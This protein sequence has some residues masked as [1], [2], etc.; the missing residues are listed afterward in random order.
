MTPVMRYVCLALLWLLLLPA[1][2]RLDQ[3]EKM[4]QLQQATKAY[5]I[6]VRWGHWHDAVAFF[7]AR[8]VDGAQP[9]PPPAPSGD[10]AQEAQEAEK[11][12]QE[13]ENTRIAL[14]SIREILFT[15][16]GGDEALAVVDISYYGS[17]GAV[18]STVDRQLWWYEPETR[19]WWLDGSLPTFR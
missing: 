6:A 5:G 15:D 3:R 19:R 17:S 13:L 18:R 12:R 8:P 1:C 2:A 16:P 9:E 14:Y 4:W 11:L 10:E 7:A